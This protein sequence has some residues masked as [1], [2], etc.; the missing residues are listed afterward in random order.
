MFRR[1]TSASWR[2]AVASELATAPTVLAKMLPRLLRARLKHGESLLHI[3]LENAQ[4]APE[5]LAIEMGEERSSWVQLADAT[6]RLAHVLSDAGVRSA[7]VV[8]LLGRNSPG[9]LAAV[10]GT[11]R[12]G[13][14][15]A[16][17]NNQLSG[18]P[19]SHAIEASGARVVLVEA[20]LEP[21]LRDC[22]EL[23][24]SLE[25]V[26][27]YGSEAFEERLRAAPANPYPPAA[28]EPD[29]DFVYI[30]TSGTTGLPKPCRVSHR[31]AVLA[32]VGFATLVFEF[33]PEDKL[34]SVLPLYHAS[35]LLLGA[36]AA[37][38]SATPL[39]IRE[40]FSASAFWDDVQ[41]YGATAILY[42]GELCRYLVNSPPHP[43]ERNNGIRIAVGNGLR[44]DVW[45]RFEE[46]FGIAQIREFYG[47]TEA[48]GF[49]INL[50]GKR[51]SVGHVP[52]N[53][54]GMLELV[55][56][57]VTEDAHPRDGHG[58]F[59]RCEA[60]EVGELLIR[61][62]KLSSAG[63]EFRGYTDEAATQAKILQDVFEKGDSYFRSGD[64]LRRDEDGFF[65]FVDRIGDTFRW[66]GENVSTAEVA[67][68]ITQSERIK[69]AT[70]VGVAVPHMEGRAG[71]AAVV[72][73][74]GFDE[75]HFAALVAE[76]PPYAQ[77]RFVRVMSQLST[78]GTFKFQKK[79]LESDGVDPSKVSDPLFVRTS[80][81]Y[82]P[83]SPERWDAISA[84]A[85]PL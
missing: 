65:Y 83:L 77:P 18:R 22:E 82:E 37:I 2:S 15:T 68:V 43:A 29:G 33:Q 44:P 12:L 67:D 52:F 57:D 45:P 42:I 56:Y 59:I 9:Y 11:S 10:L 78:T 30:Y 72:P 24:A 16:L 80:S 19:L 69:E 51:G 53:G 38:A 26:L 64:L 62:P 23:C 41:R 5:A 79:Q 14:T 76:L 35:G 28:I 20:E 13:A 55:R 39:A 73:H 54:F 1:L 36:G 60:H 61:I 81:G 31:R 8:A 58:F 49:I 17:I 34:Y 66:K 50:S 32:G 47:A 85:F 63:L 75:E 48:P 71:L 40:S 7:D 74:D 84:G 6:S 25:Q 70:V 21:A 3:V 46:R 4:S 27:V